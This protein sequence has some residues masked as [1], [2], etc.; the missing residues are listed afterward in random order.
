MPSINII[1]MNP[2]VE[3]K[4]QT[5][6]RRIYFD[7]IES[8]KERYRLKSK[9]KI[10]PK[11]WNF[12]TQSP[13]ITCPEYHQISSYLVKTK[14][15]ILDIFVEHRNL[16]F[17]SVIAKINTESRSVS[18]L[19]AEWLKS[20]EPTL[21]R[22]TIKK[23]KYIGKHLIYEDFARYD[24]EFFDGI[25]HGL[26]SEGKVNDTINK[27]IGSFKTF[28]RWAKDRGYH[29]NDIFERHNVGPS[30]SSRNEIVALSQDEISRLA[31]IELDP[32]KDFI[33]NL[34]LLS[35]HSG[36]RWSDLSRLKPEQITASAWKFEAYKTRK[37]K[38]Q[39]NI[40]FIGWCEPARS[41]AEKVLKAPFKYQEALVNR[42]LKIICEMA[43]I[44]SPVTITR[45]S[46][47]NQIIRSEEKWN[48][49]SLHTG[50]RTFISIL[51]NRGTPTTVVMKLTGIS[52]LKTLIK[53]LD[54]SDQD[55][56]RELARQAQGV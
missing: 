41:Y 12:K 6:P 38:I 8:R 33:R 18:E 24:L 53:Y 11:D 28:F 27:T 47:K 7:I 49:V 37:S 3:G 56:I 21:S 14:A 54:T 23:H 30:K 31:S 4:L 44:N 36:A 19:Y 55:V 15:D 5:T 32:R 9:F 39:I 10:L 20:L 42:E 34:F 17:F 29:S 50:R 22:L 16:P 43:G 35:C 25:I 13:K 45:M 52:S 40:P 26:I 46:G 51:L 2:K 1:L 48:F